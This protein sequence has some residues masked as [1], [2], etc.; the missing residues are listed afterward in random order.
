M[1]ARG[2]TCTAAAA[3]CDEGRDLYACDGWSA[4]D[5]AAINEMVARC[6]TQG[7]IA[8]DG[9]HYPYHLSRKRQAMLAETRTRARAAGHRARRLTASKGVTIEREPHGALTAFTAR[10]E[11]KTVGLASFSL[12][13][14]AQIAADF[15][16]E[17]DWPIEGPFFAPLSAADDTPVLWLQ[18]IEVRQTAREDF[19]QTDLFE[20]LLAEVRGLD[21][22]TFCQF[23]NPRLGTLMRRRWPAEGFTVHPGATPAAAPGETSLDA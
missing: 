4:A 3:H 2:C 13:P 1:V 17:L 14:Y 21:M 15:E 18:K 23:A 8:P 7:V 12:E 19:R 10:C 5:A 9:R 20:R 6:D 22:P 11:G 16:H